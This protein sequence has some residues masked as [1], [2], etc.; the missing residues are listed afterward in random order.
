VAIEPPFI[1]ERYV[2]VDGRA[3]CESCLRPLGRHP[4]EIKFT[5]VGEEVAFVRLCSGGLG[6]T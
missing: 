1:S 2:R 4:R 3:I 6:K 5:E